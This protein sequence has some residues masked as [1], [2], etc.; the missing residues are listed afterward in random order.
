MEPS[1]LS[2]VP[3]LAAIV[4]AL[5]LLLVSVVVLVALRGRWVGGVTP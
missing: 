2:L 5:V 1:L 3:P 4:L